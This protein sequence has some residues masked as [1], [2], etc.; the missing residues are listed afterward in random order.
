MT[1]RIRPILQAALIASLLATCGAD[2]SAL[3]SN[4]PE[5]AASPSSSSDGPLDTDRYYTFDGSVR[6]PKKSRDAAEGKGEL[7]WTADRDGTVYVADLSDHE[8][9][10]EK[11]INKGETVTV[12]P[13]DDRIRIGKRTVLRGRFP[14]R[15]RYKIYFER[16]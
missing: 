6:I 14:D 2:C 5:R 15:H 8:A 13:N 10:L 7:S 1:V 12:D 3:T 9:L 16:D 4:P 11:Q